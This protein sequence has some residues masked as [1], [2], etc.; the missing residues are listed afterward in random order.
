MK[1]KFK[2]AVPVVKAGRPPAAVEITPQGVLAAAL[3]R[4]TGGTTYAWESL[5]EGALVPGTD[6]PNLRQPNAVSAALRAV[7]DKVSPHK[8]AITVVLPDSL[9]RVFVLDFDAFPAKA[10]EALEVLR[11]RLRKSVPFDVEHAGIG[12]QVL[13]QG[14]DGIRVLAAVLPG[15]IQVEYE[16]AIRSAGYEPGA[17]LPSS[18]AALDVRESLEAML[19]ANLTS[20][21][22]TTT[23]ATGQDLLLYRT[24]DLPED[25]AQRVEEIQSG[26][27]VS[28]A[29]YE[30]KLQAR[31][32]KL[33]YAG[34]ASLE[35]FAG[36]I[37]DPELEVVELAPRPVS[38][39]L[40]SLGTTDF[41]GVAGAL[42]GAQ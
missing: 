15:P 7:L 31:P 35:E 30:D 39:V 4:L 24:L 38:G 12:Y 9:I 37:G 18:L 22:M 32:N 13:P 29:Y 19:T 42:A 11:F 21:A 34:S 8:R 14:K 10:A 27:A 23:I 36:W 40:T 3:P 20:H 17:I 5:P 33:Y 41:A 28:V 1:F 25:P 16:A 2:D 26:I 6:E